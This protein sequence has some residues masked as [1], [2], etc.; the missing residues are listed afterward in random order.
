[1]RRPRRED[2]AP[3]EP[4]LPPTVG[5]EIEPFG[6][7][8]VVSNAAAEAAL[9]RVVALVR[10]AALG[11]LL[12][13]VALVV[14]LVSAANRDAIEESRAPST[15]TARPLSRP[16]IRIP[17]VVEE[18]KLVD[19]LPTTPD[20]W[21][22]GQVL[23][24]IDSTGQLQ[25]RELVDGT[26]LEVGVLART[27]LPPLPEHI[28]LVGAPNTT[29]LVDLQE[30]DRSGKLS[31]SV[32]M[33]RL[34]DTGDSYGFISRNDTT[35]DFFVGSLWGPAINGTASVPLSTEVLTVRRTGIIVSSTAAESAVVAGGGLRELPRRLGRIV[36]ASPTR[37]AG[38]HCDSLARCIGRVTNW[39]GGDEREVLVDTL[40]A[41]VIRISPDGRFIVATGA[42][43]WTVLDLDVG[44]TKQWTLGIAA[45]DSL[46]W[47]TD[48]KTLLWEVDGDVLALSI[49]DPD[50]RLTRVRQVGNI[51]VRI[52]GSDF[53]VFASSGNG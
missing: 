14:V 13:A 50:P 41:P 35:T 7:A 21:I 42:E 46:M 3:R 8:L 6:G 34:G 12:L 48:S 2:E 19:Q 27:N 43:M 39:D 30:P 25:L 32:R 28:H 17:V 51:G 37:I 47:T 33:V 24:W 26:E 20:A 45:N 4:E 18:S 5:I 9:P 53:A 1:M 16:A 38:I 36:A 22:D 49:D 23:S 11:G 40:V 52:I 29:W 44:V 10:A 15:A 31:N